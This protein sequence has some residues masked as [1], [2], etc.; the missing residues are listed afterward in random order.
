MAR[1]ILARELAIEEITLVTLVWIPAMLASFTAGA[2]LCGSDLSLIEIFL[3]VAAYSLGSYLNTYSELQRKRW[4]QR[5]ENSGRCYTLGLFSLS[6]N[7]NYL[8]D[9]ILF[10]GWALLSSAWWNAWVP[11]TMASI[12]YFHHIPDK[13]AYLAKRYARDWPSYSA[14]TPSFIPWSNSIVGSKG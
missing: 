1:W 3:A 10:A 7:I 5:P 9:V 11:L 12:F 14:K 4:K 8:G 2:A 6:R 13:E